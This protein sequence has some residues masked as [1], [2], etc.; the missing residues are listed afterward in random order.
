MRLF[1]RGRVTTSLFKES[2]RYAI[3]AGA[4][5]ETC[6]CLLKVN[7]AKFEV[8][9]KERGAPEKNFN[10]VIKHCPWEK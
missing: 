5:T 7:T 2:V 10:P 9:S 6:S 1:N 8:Q 4:S 3:V